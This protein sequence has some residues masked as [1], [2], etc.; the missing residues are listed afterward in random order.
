MSVLKEALDRIRHWFQENHPAGIASLASGLSSLEIDAVLSTLPF[1]VAKEVRELYEW[2]NGYPKDARYDERTWIWDGIP[3]LSLDSAVQEAQTWAEE[4]YQ[5][6]AIRYMGKPVFIIC[7]GDRYSLATVATNSEQETSP[8]IYISQAGGICIGLTYTSLTTMMLTLAESYE[9][10]GFFVE[11][12]GYVER[13]E[14]K[15]AAAYRKYNSGIIDLALER[16]LE[17]FSSDPSRQSVQLLHDHLRV[18]ND[19]G[20]EIPS[21][22]LKTRV[23]NIL[24]TLLQDEQDSSDFLVVLALGKLRAVDALIQALR[25]HDKWVR[26]GA[27]FILGKIKAFEAVAFISQLSED[28]DP[29]VQE[30]VQ[31]A[32]KILR[33]ER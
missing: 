14:K 9:T 10:G 25:H 3:L 5:E 2:S 31:K 19:Y 18:I 30:A 17:I 33:N 13:D 7:E 11:H 8:I 6:I 28:P 24:L 15:Y 23:V 26:S 4:F 20:I 16:F 21:S 12:D 22:S 27:A 29:T 32:L 1:Q